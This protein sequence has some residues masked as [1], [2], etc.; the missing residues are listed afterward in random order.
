MDTSQPKKVLRQI[1]EIKP[2][3]RKLARLI[4]AYFFLIAAPT[5][6][7]NALRTSNFLFKEGVGWLPVVYLLAVAATGLLV[8]LQAKIRVRTSLRVLIIP[9]LVFFAVS[10][11][12]LQWLLQTEAGR[13]SS[14]LNYVYWVWASVLI[15]VLITGFWMTVNEIYN[16]RQA[17]RLMVFLNSGGLTGSV[18]GGVLVAF[19]SEG[20]L[21]PFLL[22]L[23]CAMLL[24]CVAVVNAIYRDRESRPAG[25]GRTGGPIGQAE[26][27]GT[28]IWESFRAVR[29]DRFLV[30]I[31]A[32]VAIGIIVS[33]GIEFQFLSAAYG[34][35]A[36]QASLQAFFGFFE[37]ALT[38]FA[39]VL[40]LLMAGFLLKRLTAPRTLLLT[41]A[42]LL[43]GSVA[44]LLVPFGLG[45]GLLMRGLDEGLAF[46]VNHPF[47]E[48]M[49]IPIPARLRH[50]AKAFIEMFVGQFAKVAGALVLLVFALAMNKQVEGL[51]PLFNYQ[52]ARYLSWVL[53]AFLLAWIWIG[54]KVGRQYL[55]I[56]KE[57]IQPLWEPPGPGL[58]E[59]VDVEYAK[60]VFDT[61]D[62]RNYSSVLY[63]L[64]L[65][66]LLA[67]NRL[68]P[69]LQKVISAKTEEVRA[70]ALSDR[71][72]T[73]SEALVPAVLNDLPAADMRTEI[74]IILSLE[75]YQ[76][77][78]GPY[79]EELL[80]RG[81]EAE[82]EKME[83]AKAI[84]LMSPVS[85]LAGRLT[86]LIDDAS[87]SVSSLALKSA[88]R[89]KKDEYIPAIIRKLSLPVTFDDAVEAL[90]GYGDRA[91]GPLERCL[92]DRSGP[93]SERAA[94]VAALGRIG[95][96]R[97]VRSLTEELEYGNGELDKAIIEALDR[98]RTERGDIPMS[99]AAAR[100]KTYALIERFC[101]DFIDLQER[102]P[103][104]QDTARRSGLQ[105]ELKVTFGNLFKV[106]GL[107][108]PQA[109][110]RRAY[111]NIAAGTPHSV[112]HAV[113]WL[114]N[115]LDKDLHDL[116]LPIVD[117]LNPK[118]K[119][120]RLKKILSDLTA[121]QS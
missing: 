99:T 60:L 92:L 76:R 98:L 23:A 119:T 120:A 101:R 106:L 11:S 94:A 34:H 110:I 54:L 47:R 35:Y 66:D 56:L 21:G 51:T 114:D 18:L 12:V 69:D 7:V 55:A 32:V 116:V 45:P 83:L 15:T 117:D 43:V 65:F 100:R 90:R 71:L 73:G 77:V 3:E 80:E 72:E 121:R 44:V 59:K 41:P 39:F 88:A 118:E 93:L 111:Q 37:A 113:E 91:V 97:A 28:G 27:W 31:A 38:A 81:P 63:A 9:S 62:S 36:R 79:A 8:I 112:A 74:P 78:M 19:L 2:G 84:G 64:H 10:G 20:R 16:P 75:A 115:A 14:A 85:A 33:T 107:Y 50:K 57:N 42:V 1:V 53:I 58:A 86:R 87:A 5:T 102:G 40:N 82:V 61:V 68:T 104:L 17:K 52:L 95:T 13:R 105:K 89:L 6:M 25:G 48:I 49:Y 46:S 108:Y 109:D 70:R 22:P 96:R 29:K 67:Q 30:L 103:G 4:F 24:G 26:G